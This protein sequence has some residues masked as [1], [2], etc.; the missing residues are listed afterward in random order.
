VKTFREEDEAAKKF[1]FMTAND[2]KQLP[3]NTGSH[4]KVH[5][6]TLNGNDV[7]VSAE[8]ILFAETDD[9]WVHVL[10]K[11]KKEYLW[12]MPHC[13]L[14]VF[15]KCMEGKKFYQISK[16]YAASRPHVSSFHRRPA[17]L[18]FDNEFSVPLKHHVD[19]YAMNLFLLR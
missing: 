15:M 11:E 18:V 14:K 8:N 12:L 10:V 17:E 2:N 4:D 9:H 5:L 3:D 1:F 6:R 19:P 13:S 16:F 7:F